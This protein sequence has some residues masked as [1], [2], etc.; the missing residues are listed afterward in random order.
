MFAKF[1]N[2]MPNFL[3]LSHK[4]TVGS[5]AMKDETLNNPEVKETPD[6]KLDQM[7]EKGN[8]DFYFRPGLEGIPACQ[9]N[10]GYIDGVRGILEYRGVR[11]EELA[12]K[13][14]F[15]E[16]SFLLL[17]AKLP[18]ADFLKKWTLDLTRHRRLPEG[19]LDTLRRYPQTAHPMEV[20]QSAVAAMGMYYHGDDVSEEEERFHSICRIIAKI[21]TI[22]GAFHRIRNGEEPILPNDDLSHSANFLYMVTGKVPSE[23][24]ARL[25][26]ACLILHAE[27]GLNASTFAARAVGSTLADPYAVA[28][29]AIAS[30]SGPLHGGANERVIN[31]F[32]E[33]ETIENVRPWVEKAV[34]EKRRIM[35]LG[36][37]VYKTKDPRAY[38]LETMAEEVFQGSNDR[39][40]MLAME[41]EK[42]AGE[43]L[44]SKGIFSNVDFYSGL[45]YRQLGFTEDLFTT[46]FAAARSAGW[47]AHWLEQ[48]EGNRIYRPTQIYQGDRN[49][50]YIPAEER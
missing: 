33:I 30:L 13:S 14:N 35:G 40:L 21:P 1:T 29:S 34:A 50:P 39:C 37:R 20:L 4:K 15:E 46:I 47:L 12:E 45:V 7:I 17:H 44:G 11:I 25:F 31:M 22:I 24:E 38:V 32:R 2:F 26:D 10:I 41:V 8:V 23:R 27:H 36:H 5:L 16:V 28:S 18:K 3:D 48:L 42:V 19:L 43:M 6:Q 9:S 49:M